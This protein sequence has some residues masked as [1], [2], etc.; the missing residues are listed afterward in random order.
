MKILRTFWLLTLGFSL[1]T[2]AYF[3]GPPLSLE[4]LAAEADFIFKGTALG[5]EQVRD[6]SFK[7][8][9]GFAACETKFK[10]IS[11]LKGGDV[12]ETISFRHYQST[13]TQMWGGYEP[14]HYHFDAGQTYLVFAKESGLGANVSRQ[15]SPS[16]TM[17]WDQG[18]LRC[19]DAKP[20]FGSTVP[21]V[22]WNELTNML[23]N[24]VSTNV[25]YAI[26]QM[27]QMS[28]DSNVFGALKDFDRKEVLARVHDL[29]NHPD[30]DVAQKALQVIGSR[31]PYLFE[32]DAPFWLAAVGRG[33]VVGLVPRDTKRKN[34]GGELYWRDLEA[35]ASGPRPAEVR[36]GAIRALGRV[37]QP[38]LQPSIYRWLKDTNNL[39]RASATVLLADISG[40]EATQSLVALT[41][42]S[43]PEVR[44]C[45]AYAIGYSQR[46]NSGASSLEKLLTDKDQSVRKAAAMSLLSFSLNEKNV[47]DIFRV[48]LTNEEFHPL[49]LNAL[50]QEDPKGH[51]E[52]LAEAVEARADPK[53]WWGG[54]T[55]AFTSWKI[56]FKYIQNQP[57]EVVRSGKLDRY[58]DALEK[59]GN[60]SSGE[61]RDIY[62]LY[63]QRG[64]NERAKKYRAAAAKTVSYNLD[65]YFDQVDRYPSHY[66]L[67]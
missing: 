48:N 58:L 64:L 30:T 44:A 39:V 14:Q 12:G 46:S 54:Q 6:D 50:A 37:N 15:I 31:N 67:E 1:A 38:E 56:L 61:P 34:L 36:A 17:K 13:P 5:T 43:A 47:A 3:V 27:D 24:V 7:S 20:A 8:V 23:R 32:R 10:V 21:E 2:R 19:P 40:P 35:M 42:D 9:S 11:A 26:D 62:A 18:V 57:A 49:F 60:Y 51:L 29:M 59:V 45:A 55:P 22:F 66:L 28:S 4:K 41:S 65:Y 52:G 53:N 16:H 63:V 33:K 25:T